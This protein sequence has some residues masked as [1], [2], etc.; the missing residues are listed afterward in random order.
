MDTF[1]FY[2]ETDIMEYDTKKMNRQIEFVILSKE[3]KYT[4]EKV[5]EL[6]EKV[7]YSTNNVKKNLIAENHLCQCWDFYVD[8]HEGSSLP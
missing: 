2:T 1:V 3:P 7:Q 8:P 5:E 6:F 4:E